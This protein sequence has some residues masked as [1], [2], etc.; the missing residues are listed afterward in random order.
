MFHETTVEAAIKRGRDKIPSFFR[1]NLKGWM[2]V[3][4]QKR[5]G[6]HNSEVLTS[7]AGPYRAGMWY[8]PLHKGPWPL[9]QAQEDLYMPLS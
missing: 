1:Q 3:C 2:S 9:Q 7:A 5:E 8:S 4:M 6:F